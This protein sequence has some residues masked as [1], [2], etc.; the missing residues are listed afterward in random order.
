MSI[1]KRVV[2]AGALLVTAGAL[3]AGFVSGIIP[4]A[5]QWVKLGVRRS[6]G[7]SVPAGY[8]NE[9]TPSEPEEASDDKPTP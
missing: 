3:T 6:F 5:A 1:E 2:V 7:H 4:T 8:V 9:S